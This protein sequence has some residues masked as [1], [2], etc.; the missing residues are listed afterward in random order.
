MRSKSGKQ[1]A[2]G[3]PSDPHNQVIAATYRTLITTINDSVALPTRSFNPDRVAA[4]RHLPRSVSAPKR[5]TDLQSAI[6][7]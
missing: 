3:R 1:G 7:D 6:R 4:Y 2:R 5:P